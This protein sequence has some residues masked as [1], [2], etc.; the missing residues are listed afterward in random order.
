M[1][2]CQQCGHFC[3][4]GEGAQYCGH[5]LPEYL[6]KVED[7]KIQARRLVRVMERDLGNPPPWM[8]FGLISCARDIAKV[9]D[10]IDNPG[11][12]YASE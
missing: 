12:A 7:L 6:A 8:T 11:G 1:P 5:C 2:V 4:D 9:L 3:P 10:A